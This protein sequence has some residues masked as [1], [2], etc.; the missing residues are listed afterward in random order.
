MDWLENV[1]DSADLMGAP[2]D[3]PAAVGYNRVY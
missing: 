1:P 2:F 3:A